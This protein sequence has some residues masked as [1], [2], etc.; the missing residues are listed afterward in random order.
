MRKEE[1]YQINDELI[2]EKIEVPVKSN[3]VKYIVAIATSI[4]ILA[5]V[6]V[7]LVGH[8]K[9]NWFQSNIYK[10]DAHISRNIYQ[11]NYFT[12]TKTIDA[13]Y[14]FTNGDKGKKKAIVST[15]FIVVLTDKKKVEKDIFLNTASLI[16]LDSSVNMDETETELA[17]FHIFDEDILQK[18]SAEPDGS[19]YPMA[20]FSFYED[21]T[22]SEIKV[23][24]NMDKYNAD[25]IVELIENVIPRL[26]R[27][28]KEDMSNGLEITEKKTNKGK[29]IVESLTAVPASLLGNPGRKVVNPTHK[30]IVK[31]EIENDQVT[32]IVT[33]TSTLFDTDEE[34]LDKAV[35][36]VKD[37]KYDTQSE[38]N[39]WKI[40]EEKETAEIAKLVADKF[41]FVSSEE[42][43]EK[44]LEKEKQEQEIPVK[45]EDVGEQT[46]PLRQL[47]F[48]FNVDKTFN[49]KTI[50]FL[51]QS[52]SI[53]YRIAVKNGKAINQ[54][55][56]DSSLGK[57]TFGN[58]GVSVE[59]DKNWSGRIQVFK[60]V[61]PPVPAISLGVYAGGSLGISIHFTTSQKTT[62]KL[63]LSGSLTASAE[64]KAGW[65]K[66]LS[67]SA[68]ADG[69]IIKATGYATVTGGSVSKGYSISGGK[70]VCYVK[71]K[72][73][74]KQVWKKSHTLFNGWSS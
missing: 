9:F 21:G 6:S 1:T 3:K 35:F 16:I 65:D 60:F 29:I 48:N 14:S 57:A 41:N 4:A 55:I 11:T 70:I 59:I 44:I 49:I 2:D 25:S 13:E 66:V 28:R 17:S 36:G 10:L 46:G 67:L 53:K 31:R 58:D 40:E 47:G 63:S 39:A 42:L 33:E 37:F 7:L 30:K 38:I 54:L 45:F 12:E 52:I 61:F 71:A 73:L 69:T 50:K 23:P 62:L 26:T 27:N 20:V 18:L 24:D 56:I 22:V 74:G 34:D 72:L 8:F 32:N 19:K 43:I 51:K 68:G 15:N 64:I 5:A